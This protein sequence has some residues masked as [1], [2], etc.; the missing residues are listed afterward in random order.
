MSS[1]S[2]PFFYR[3]HNSSVDWDDSESEGEENRDSIEK[4]NVMTSYS[5]IDQFP[6][7]K[8]DKLLQAFN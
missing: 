5:L 6:G 8:L 1:T 4:V 2:F 7:Y 3:K